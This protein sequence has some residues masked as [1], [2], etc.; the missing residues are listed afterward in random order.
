MRIAAAFNRRNERRLFGAMCAIL[1]CSGVSFAAPS[2]EK[3][4][5]GSLAAP[6]SSKQISIDAAIPAYKKTSGVAGQLNS[7]GSDTLNN[8]MTLWAEK[9]ST[10]YPNVKVQVEGKGSGTAPPALIAGTAQLGPMSREMKASE[11]DEFEKKFSH[12]P[13]RVRVAVDALG[14]FVHK[15]NPIKGLTIE[16]LDAIFSKSRKQG[17]AAD[18]LTWGQLG[19]SGE[20][21]NKPISLYGRNAASGTYGFFK[22][23]VLKNG[24]FKDLVKEQ[25][26]SASVVQGIAVDK[27]AIGYS[28]IGYKTSGVR[29]IP[30]KSADNADFVEGTPENAYSGEYALSRFLYVYVNKDPRAGLE[31]LIKEFLRMVLSAEG[32]N[33]V[34]KDGYYPLTA[35]VV[36]E[37]LAQLN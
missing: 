3:A 32:Q 26:G 7:I 30:L 2:A 29:A 10:F 16:Q 13:T 34:V 23:H 33:V 36:T 21:A 25:P 20:W 19:L 8:V 14:V 27:F 18:I 4:G 22:E 31:P 9:Y 11:S 17:A 24:D 12:K 6:E 37:E 28:G 35:A 1:F 15:D 5:M